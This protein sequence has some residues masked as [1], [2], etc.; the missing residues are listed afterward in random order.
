MENAM[1]S[2]G[3]PEYR[4]TPGIPDERGVSHP[5]M[6][7]QGPDE[8]LYLRVEE[9]EAARQAY[10][11]CLPGFIYEETDEGP[12]G[13]SAQQA[14]RLAEKANSIVRSKSTLTSNWYDFYDTMMPRGV[15]CKKP[16]THTGV[17][18]SAASS[19]TGKLFKDE[20]SRSNSNP[21]KYKILYP[22]YKYERIAVTPEKMQKAIQEAS[23]KAWEEWRQYDTK[24]RATNPSFDEIRSGVEKQISYG[25]FPGRPPTADDFVAA[26]RTY[27]EERLKAYRATVPG[28]LKPAVWD[29][30]SKY[31]A[32]ETKIDLEAVSG[33]F[34][35]ADFTEFCVYAAGIILEFLQYTKGVRNQVAFWLPHEA[36]MTVLTSV[37][38]STWRRA[39]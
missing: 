9:C 26:M 17:V 8:A 36:P 38:L 35:P 14:V 24:F 16:V 1:A 12:I 31:A 34:L 28:R 11:Q 25:Y 13:A 30:I 37:Q 10:I 21:G 3:H 23:V 22:G 2:I 20:W 4:W 33:Y 6:L 5:Y 15:V 27:M 18:M 32:D 39:G 7:R 29:A 19:I